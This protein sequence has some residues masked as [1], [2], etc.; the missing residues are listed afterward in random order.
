MHKLIRSF[1][2][3]SILFLCLTITVK[4]DNPPDPGG[5]PTGEP[6]GG[7]SPIG[8]GLVISIILSAMYGSGKT[9]QLYKQKKLQH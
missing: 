9:Y 4:A 8:S 5:G 2:I 7:G 6:V 3:T 1:I